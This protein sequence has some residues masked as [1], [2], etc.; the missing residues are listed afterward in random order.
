MYQLQSDAVFFE[1][2]RPTLCNW[3]Q[4]DPVDSLEWTRTYMIAKYQDNKP[5]PFVLDCS[6]TRRTF[7]NLNS[8]CTP[9]ANIELTESQIHLLTNPVHDELQIQISD[10]S[11]NLHSI[12]ITDITGKSSYFF[13]PSITDTKLNI[14]TDGI[15][16]GCYVLVIRTVDNK[17]WRRVF[18]KG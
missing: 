3:H 13:N 11:L 7:C 2:M 8:S 9:S 6:L 5:N 1:S 15:P 10:F 16:S 4:L 18:V 12:Q 17:I 14:G